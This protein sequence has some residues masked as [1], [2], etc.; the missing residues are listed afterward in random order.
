MLQPIKHGVSRYKHFNDDENITPK[1]VMRLIKESEA[2]IS[3][4]IIK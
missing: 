4:I 3:D 2:D 1:E